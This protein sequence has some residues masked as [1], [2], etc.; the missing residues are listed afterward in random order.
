MGHGTVQVQRA[1]VDIAALSGVAVGDDDGRPGDEAHGQTQF[2]L[3]GHSL[4]VRVIGIE[5][6]DTTSQLVHQVAAGGAE[7]LILGEHG[8]QR[9]QLIQHL[10]EPIQLFSGGQVAHEQQERRLLIAKATFGG[11]AQDQIFYVDAPVDHLAGHG[12]SF[13][14]LHIV[15]IHVANLCHAHHNTGPIVVTQT[16]LDVDPFGRLWVD[17]IALGKFVTHLMEKVIGGG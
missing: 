11:E 15:A 7:D 6:Q 5:G 12:Y 14:V 4:R 1:A 8:R 10:V 9:A 13:A 2:V 17:L 16:A 3:Q